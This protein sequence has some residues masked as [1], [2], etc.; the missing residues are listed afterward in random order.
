MFPDLKH[1]RRRDLTEEAA[2]TIDSLD[3]ETMEKV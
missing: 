1:T 2:A 3:R